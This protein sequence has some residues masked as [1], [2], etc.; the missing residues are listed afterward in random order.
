MN[1]AG[2]D[3]C[4]PP[5]FG[6]ENSGLCPDHP[7]ECD[8]SNATVIGMVETALESLDATS[9]PLQISPN[10]SRRKI[11]YSHWTAGLSHQGSP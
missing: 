4:H 9:G 6:K 10:L 5:R 8:L 3:S 11:K 1:R 2:E 7:H